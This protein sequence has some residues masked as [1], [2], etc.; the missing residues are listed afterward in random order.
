MF[1][2]SGFWLETLD[3]A[4]PRSHVSAEKPDILHSPGRAHVPRYISSHIPSR[5][6]SFPFLHPT[7]QSPC[8]CPCSSGTTHQHLSGVSSPSPIVRLL[9]QYG[10]NSIAL[11]RW[12]M[13][14]CKWTAVEMDGPSQGI[15]EDCKD[16]FSVVENKIMGTSTF[17]VAH[18]RPAYHHHRLRACR[19][20]YIQGNHIEGDQH[21]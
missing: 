17:D 11:S 9:A 12:W 1:L 5:S 21:G 4:I 3:T 20:F 16:Y 10:Q 2:R 19:R 14:K 18:C 6:P 13:D 15:F 8:P 7:V